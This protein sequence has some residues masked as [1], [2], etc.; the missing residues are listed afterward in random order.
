M[1]IS[2][3]RLIRTVRKARDVQIARILAVSSFNMYFKR[4]ITPRLEDSRE[5]MKTAKG[6]PYFS[7]DVRYTSLPLKTLFPRLTVSV[8]GF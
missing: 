7:N 8:R 3:T 1:K 5:S 4:K 6:N 2:Y